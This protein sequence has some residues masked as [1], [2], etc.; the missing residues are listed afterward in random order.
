MTKG[1]KDTPKKKKKRKQNT[2]LTISDV[3]TEHYLSAIRGWCMDGNTDKEIAEKLGIGYTTLRRWRAASDELKEAMSLTKE[4][5]DSNVEYSLYK[6]ALS[7]DV[8]A[9]IYWLN[10]RKRN[11]WTRD[12]KPLQDNAAGTGVIEIPAVFEEIEP[13]VVEEMKEK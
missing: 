5:A 4:V 11:K 10:N 7:G 8:M 3:T 9:C 2:R 1:Q 13:A 6:K 12:P